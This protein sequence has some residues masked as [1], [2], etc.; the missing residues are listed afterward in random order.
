MS[1]MGIYLNLYMLDVLTQT[2]LES[3]LIKKKSFLTC[4]IGW[5]D[6]DLSE[7]LVCTTIR[8]VQMLDNVHNA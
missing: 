7:H 8:N 6:Y 2:A 5:H 1:G 4:F 3:F